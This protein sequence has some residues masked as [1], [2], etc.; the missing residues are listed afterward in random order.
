[1]CCCSAVKCV[2]YYYYDLNI[3]NSQMLLNL[4]K[5]TWMD[6]LQLDGFEQHCGK[7]QDAMKGIV[8]LAKAYNKV[9]KHSFI[10][11]LCAYVVVMGFIFTRRHQGRYSIVTRKQCQKYRNID[12]SLSFF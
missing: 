7:N 6:S 5:R 8:K 1:M 11:S 2:C 9:N 4:N 3:T 10:V 12:Y